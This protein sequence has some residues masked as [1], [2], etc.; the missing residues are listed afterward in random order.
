M[1]IFVAGCLVG[2]IAGY[3]ARSFRG[4]PEA[5]LRNVTQETS[6]QRATLATVL[7]SRG[8]SPESITHF[9]FIGDEHSYTQGRVA[10]DTNVTWIWDR[11]IRT[12]E[13]YSFWEASGN[14]RV[15]VF[16]RTGHQPAVVLLVNTTDATSVAGDDRRFMCHGLHDLA[17]HL[18]SPTQAAQRP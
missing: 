14:R 8:I 10:T 9:R 2:I 17:M 3:T 6:A 18:L 11:M 12:A 5:Q 16:T 7:Q 13:P 15:E 1:L 4:A